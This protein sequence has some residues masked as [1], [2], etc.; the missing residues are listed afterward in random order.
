MTQ[1][2]FY[3]SMPWLRARKAFI[4]ERTLIDGGMCQV[5]GER[6]GKI[7]HHTIWLND[8]NCNDPD[9]ALN[10]KLFRYECHLCHNKEVDP[11]RNI[12]NNGRACYLPN[13]TV[14]KRGNY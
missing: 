5:C 3:K 10:P 8:V 6:P 4:E 1:K 14:V 9:I 2:E 7:V 13:G 12:Y 11:A